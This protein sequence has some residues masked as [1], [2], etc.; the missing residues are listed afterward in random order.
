MYRHHFGL[1]TQ[2]FRIVPNPKFLYASETH[3]E[4]RARI[5]YG[6]R[7]GRGF[8][9]VSGGV[10]LGKTT[11]LLSVLEELDAKVRTAL[12]FNPVDTYHQLLRMICHE[13]GLPT[14][15][16]DEVELLQDLQ[17]FLIERLAKGETCVLLIDEAQNLSVEVLERVRTLSNLQT[18]HAFLMQIVLVGQPELYQRLMDPRLVQLRQRVGIWHEIRPLREDEA[19]DYILH[20]LR[21]AGAMRPKEI[22]AAD[23]CARVHA[24]SRGVPRVINQICDTAL[25]IA[26]GR[27]SRTVREEHVA[28]AARELHLAPRQRHASA[29]RPKPQDTSL[30]APPALWDER[31]PPGERAPHG[32]RRWALAL[33]GVVL[34]TAGAVYALSQP[35][36]RSLLGELRWPWAGT[37][38]SAD[39]AAPT[40]STAAREHAR[41]AQV[42]ALL[43]PQA[44]PEPEPAAQ[45]APIPSGSNPSPLPGTLALADPPGSVASA[46]PQEAAQ[47]RTL[48]DQWRQQGQLVYSVHVGSF[49][50]LAEAQA[51][52]D[53]LAAGGPWSE[54][55]YVELTGA[56]PQWY[57]VLAGGFQ[58][59]D[60]ARGWIQVLKQRGFGWTQLSPLSPEARDLIPGAGSMGGA[61]QSA[62]SGV[63][64]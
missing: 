17:S 42:S 20:R 47:R 31:F 4:S 53:H 22:I 41:V 30:P 52:A 21:L 29:R 44:R 54:P 3:D 1:H 8:V 64:G 24:W 63:Q 36:V 25:L 39:S 33:A 59:P 9:V 56:H 43:V 50:S 18:D 38:S 57:R 55:L 58:E 34:L 49:Q 14:A 10:G 46:E 6:I 5:L 40:D 26:Y 15:A 45:P 48:V 32:R 23:V 11:V 16:K 51:F 60:Q 2:P 19:E 37:P 62:S 13:F 28:E 35:R 7:E 61:G 12:I 27:D